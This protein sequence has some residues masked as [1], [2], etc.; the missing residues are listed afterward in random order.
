MTRFSFETLGVVRALRESA[1]SDAR[2]VIIAKGLRATADGYV[3]IILPAYLLMLGRS[4][5]EIGALM[6]AT[7]LGSALLT[8][9]AGT[10]SSILGERRALVAA[11]LLMIATGLGFSFFTDF[12]PLLVIAFAGTLNPSSGD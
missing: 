10:I 11:A 9:F 7:L 2:R 6:T 1:T 5:F 12:W 4:P 8:V 3:S